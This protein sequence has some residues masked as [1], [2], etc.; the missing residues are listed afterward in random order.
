MVQIEGVLEN[1]SLSIEEKATTKQGC[2]EQGEKR[3]TIWAPRAVVKQMAPQ[4]HLLAL[5]G[6]Y[7]WRPNHFY[8]RKEEPWRVIQALRFLVLPLVLGNHPLNSRMRPGLSPAATSM[9]ISQSITNFSRN[10]THACLSHSA[11]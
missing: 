1:I 9:Q 3:G 8:P 11:L 6:V 2:H 7:V 5:P 10:K 4:P